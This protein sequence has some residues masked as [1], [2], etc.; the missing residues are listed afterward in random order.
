MDTKTTAIISG[1]IELTAIDKS[2]C[3]KGKNGKLYLPITAKILNKSTYGNNV[4]IVQT[5]TKEDRE[6]KVRAITLGNA[7]VKWLGDE[8][9]TVAERTEVTNTEHNQAREVELD[10]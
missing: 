1:S 10:F 2:K 6:N 4:W 5:Q 9:V 8:P 3:V 7:G